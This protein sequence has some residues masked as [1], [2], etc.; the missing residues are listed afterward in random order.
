MAAPKPSPDLS[1]VSPD[2][3]SVE[4]EERGAARES[5]ERPQ[6][7]TRQ[8]RSVLIWLLAAVIAVGTLLF[9]KQYQRAERLAAQ[10]LAQEAELEAASQQLAAYQSHLDSV[11]TSVGD[12]SDRIG[13]LQTLV[14]RDPLA[15]PEVPPGGA[16][17][18][19]PRLPARLPVQRGTGVTVG[20][21]LEGV[22]T[23]SPPAVEEPP[24]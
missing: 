9:V 16:V 6:A 15:E 20:G 18:A 22:E 24:A 3:H 4:R 12:L 2:A 17:Q 23:P 7:P 5:D 1:V 10:V 14:S 13:V 21:V 11:R 19:E 8:R